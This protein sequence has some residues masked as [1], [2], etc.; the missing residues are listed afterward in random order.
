MKH[1]VTKELKNKEMN[2]NTY[3]QRRKVMNM[4]YLLKE[5]I[6]LPRIE[7]RVTENHD[8]WLGMG[9]LGGKGIVIWITEFGTELRDSSLLHLVAH[10]IGHSVFKLRHSDD[11][12]LMKQG[13]SMNSPASLETIIK[14]LK[15]A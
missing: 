1:T 2:K 6:D 15:K 4:I 5:H 3:A 11:C 12:P 9:V 10:E 7:V 8:K 14:V 13:L